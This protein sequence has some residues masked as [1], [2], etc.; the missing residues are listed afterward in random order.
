MEEPLTQREFDL[1]READNQFKV[2]LEAFIDKQVE[3]NED[4]KVRLKALEVANDRSVMRTG[5][6]AT[7]V[8][9]IGGTVIHT[10]FKKMGW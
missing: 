10:L 2:R 4:A 3:I 7:V 5:L 6:V 9:G 1:W 8:S